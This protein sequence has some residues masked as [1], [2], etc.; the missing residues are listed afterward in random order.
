MADITCGPLSA[1]FEH[2]P[3]SKGDLRR[4][5]GLVDDEVVPLVDEV[6]ARAP[7]SVVALGGTVRALARLVAVAHG[8][9]L[10]ADSVTNHLTVT[11]A[12][13]RRVQDDL[14]ALDY[15]RRLDVPGMKDAR[16]DHIHVAAII[17]VEVFDRLG[18]EEVTVSDWGLREGLLLDA[19]GATDVLTG[20]EL[21]RR[22]VARVQA[23]FL[24][25][26]D[27]HPD[28]VAE[29]AGLL[30]DELVDVHEL[31]DDDRELLQHAAHLHTIGEALALRRSHRHG[32][33]LLENAELRGF[34]PHD[35]A[36]LATLV[37]FHGARGIDRRFAPAASLDAGRRRRVERLLPLLQLADV[38]D[39]ARDQAVHDVH[40][41]DDGEVV[42]VAVAG[43]PHLDAADLERRAAWFQ[44]VFDRRLRLVD[45][46][47]AAGHG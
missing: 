35:I 47:T 39:R 8:V 10:P 43:D 27:A 1:S 23:T 5:R 19:L 3:P 16:A 12:Q 13:L 26:D 33:Y 15:G 2:D 46:D 44:R 29:L 32:A 40:A 9:W 31:G 42:T 45:A 24:P 34:A 20:P 28:H 22:E 14:V 4:L 6:A 11:T 38:L 25:A 36:V 37:R 17:L 41:D 30:F 21:R 7:A 18:I